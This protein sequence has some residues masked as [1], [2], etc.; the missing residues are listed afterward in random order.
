M[1]RRRYSRRTAATSL[2]AIVVISI[3]LGLIFLFQRATG[4]DLE[5]PA[6]ASTAILPTGD[7]ASQTTPIGGSWYRV[8]FT[9][10]SGSDDPATYHGG[11]DAT[12]AASLATA[13]RSIDVA[14]YEFNLFSLADALIAAQSRGVPVRLVTDTDSMKEEAIGRVR[15]AGIPVV[16]D[17]RE[18]IMH[19]KFVVIDRAIVWT[20]SMNFTTNDVYRNDNNFI[21]ITSPR[22]A[23]NYTAE[24][25]EMFADRQFGPSSP[26]NTPNPQITIDGTAI[27]NYFSSEDGVAAHVMDAIGTAQQSIDFMAFTFTHDGIAQAIIDRA[28]AGVRARGVFETRQAEGC[29]PD[30]Y[31]A[32]S[33]A[34]LDVLED[35][36]AYTMHHKV[37]ILDGQTVIT[38]SYNFTLS[39][40]NSNDENVLIIH[41][42][43]MAAQ[44]EAEF[45]RVWSKASS[46]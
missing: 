22:L 42:A 33:D 29:C 18:P 44:Y 39:A 41:N 4:L 32:M 37:I 1:S 23:A 21:Q 14:V 40:E 26:A 8:Y 13:A 17:E 7:T 19:D 34:R 3:C 31:Q 20:G 16:A 9:T 35:G 10:P 43:E 25:E 28:K 12:L 2:G 38:G 30:V 45:G 6:T 15:A 27:E 24:F 5:S 46:Q 11:V 36:N